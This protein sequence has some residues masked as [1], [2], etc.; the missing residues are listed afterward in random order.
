M[1]IV[2]GCVCGV[3]KLLIV[4]ATVLSCQL[5]GCGMVKIS[6]TKD[7]AKVILQYAAVCGWRVP[8]VCPVCNYV[9]PSG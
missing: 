6:Y 3:F 7:H 4:I 9:T 8:V 5:V 2:H 1:Y